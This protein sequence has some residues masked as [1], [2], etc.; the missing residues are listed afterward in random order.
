MYADDLTLIAPSL[1]SLQQMV[2]ICMDEA[3]CISMQ[4]NPRK[5]SVI[6]FGPRYLRECHPITM[7]GKQV[8]FV[9]DAKYLGVIL[10]SYKKFFVLD[11]MV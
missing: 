9:S 8:A 11:Y 10:Q 1:H 5:C 3:S 2:D 6:C 4:F 7:Y